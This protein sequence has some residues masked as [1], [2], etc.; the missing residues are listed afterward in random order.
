MTHLVAMKFGEVTI[1]DSGEPIC[2]EI[3][4]HPVLPEPTSEGLAQVRIVVDHQDPHDRH[5]VVDQAPRKQ[6]IV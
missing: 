5:G 4:R 3:D 1:E 6:P 2:C